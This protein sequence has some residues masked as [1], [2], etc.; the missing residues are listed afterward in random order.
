MSRRR[1]SIDVLENRNLLSSVI[2][3][4]GAPPQPL[5]AV[6]VVVNRGAFPSPGPVS[7][8]VPVLLST[9]R[10]GFG[11]GFSFWNQPGTWSGRGGRGSW[12]G[13]FHQNG[14]GS[15]SSDDAPPAVMGPMLTTSFVSPPKGPLGSPSASFDPPPDSQDGPMTA[16]LAPRGGP[17]AFSFGDVFARKGP[18]DPPFFA[19]GRDVSRGSFLPGSMLS[20]QLAQEE[21]L[22]GADPDPNAAATTSTGP[23]TTT[24]AVARS[25][26]PALQ[27]TPDLSRTALSLSLVIDNPEIAADITPDYT[28]LP[29]RP[30]AS[31]PR[32]A[33]EAAVNESGEAVQTVATDGEPEDEILP[34]HAAGLIASVLPYDQR[35]LEEAVDHFLDQLQELNVGSLIEPNPIRTIVMSAVVIGAGVAVETARRRLSPRRRRNQ[36]PRLWDASESEELLGFPELPGSW[37]TRWI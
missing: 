32:V 19:R 14:A 7:G 22:R 6:T 26:S 9:N 4:S 37:S 31:P 35:S 8:F 24:D 30:A 11:S 13:S 3:G 1:P 2:L 29:A 27:P 34:P 21:S 25:V 16:M 18:G 23:A 10:V 33:N 20:L 5:P 28:G 36:S 15:S 12:W 17:W